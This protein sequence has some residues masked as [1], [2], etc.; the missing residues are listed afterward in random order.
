MKPIDAIKKVAWLIGAVIVIAICVRVYKSINTPPEIIT[1]APTDTS[2]APITQTTYR[3]QS[4][5][6]IEHPVKPKIELPSNL[7]EK[8]VDR[9]IVI[10]NN[11]NPKSKSIIII[12]NDGNIHV[13]KQDGLVG[14]V[15]VYNYLPPILN[16]DWYV[17]LG[18]DGN[19]DKISPMV[20]ISFLEIMG[21]VQLP[22]FALDLDGIGLGLDYAIFEPISIGI[23]YHNSWN[24]NKSIRLTLCWNF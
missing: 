20:G 2:F 21:R 6:L 10:T 5:P 19:A 11:T 22:V 3:P 14:S 24:T 16:F 17:K 13:P 12:D 15:E 9:A 7:R 8:D 1:T 4:I 23:I 18:I